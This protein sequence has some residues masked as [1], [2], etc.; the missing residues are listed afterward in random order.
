M[1]SWL[2]GIVIARKT[3]AKEQKSGSK[4]DNIKCSQN[5]KI[6][7]KDI[8]PKSF[9]H[10]FNMGILLKNSTLTYASLTTWGLIKWCFQE[11]EH[12]IVKRQLISEKNCDNISSTLWVK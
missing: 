1:S 5:R 12:E 4:L 3:L 6:L 10:F 9:H 2:S 8:W 7:A 11:A